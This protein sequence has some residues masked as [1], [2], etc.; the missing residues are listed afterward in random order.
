MLT[1]NQIIHYLEGF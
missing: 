1:G